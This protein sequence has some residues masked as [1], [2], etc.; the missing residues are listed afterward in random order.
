MTIAR[1]PRAKHTANKTTELQ[2][3]ARVNR[4]VIQSITGPIKKKK[5]KRLP[6]PCVPQVASLEL[7]WV[8]YDCPRSGDRAGIIR[9]R[10]NSTLSLPFRCGRS[11]RDEEKK[12]EREESCNKISSLYLL[13]GINSKSLDG[14][15]QRRKKEPSITQCWNITSRVSM[16]KCF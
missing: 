3:Q 15:D 6:K 9:V 4:R 13:E 12:G 5:K 14:P 11:T 7:Q 1:E 16:F 10:K 2:G 8:N